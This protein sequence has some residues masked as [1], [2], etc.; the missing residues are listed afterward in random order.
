MITL[1]DI[2]AQLREHMPTLQ[3]RFGVKQ[4]SVFGSYARGEQTAKS[5]L[6]LLVE[7]ERTPGL[8]TFIGLA[9][10]LESVLKVKVDLATHAMLRP[11]LRPDILNDLVAV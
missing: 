3:R 5:D 10:H 11:R 9:E 2:Q 4:I 8:F 7:F 1:H 6:D